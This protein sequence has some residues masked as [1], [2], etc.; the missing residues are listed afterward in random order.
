[1]HA[2]GTWAVELLPDLLLCEPEVLPSLARARSKLR[3]MGKSTAN[4]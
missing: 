2:D 3:R 1:M 4:Y